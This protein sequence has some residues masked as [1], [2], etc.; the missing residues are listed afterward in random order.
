[1]RNMEILLSQFFYKSKTIP[2]LKVYLK[3]KRKKKTLLILTSN[4]SPT[5]KIK[6]SQAQ[7]PHACN[8]SYPVGSNEEDHYLKAALGK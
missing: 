7:G 1:M 4:P 2:K 3:K 5:K 8:P 6:K